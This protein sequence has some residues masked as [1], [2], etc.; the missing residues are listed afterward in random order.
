M[1]CEECGA[2]SDDQARSRRALIGE[3]DDGELMVATFCPDCA[4]RE[5]GDR[6][7]TSRVT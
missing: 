4:A 3:E 7:T 2:K 6:M 5:F 1:N